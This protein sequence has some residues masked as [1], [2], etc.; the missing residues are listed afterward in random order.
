[1]KAMHDKLNDCDYQ[2]KLYDSLDLIV[3]SDDFILGAVSK[4]N[5]VCVCGRGET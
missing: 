4:T 1:M 2:F 3:T 5:A